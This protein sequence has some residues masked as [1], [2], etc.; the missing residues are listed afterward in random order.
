M[1]CEETFVYD[2]NLH[3]CV[4]PSNLPH[5]SN[6]QCIQCGEFQ[7]W[8]EEASACEECPEDAPY[9][10][11]GDCMACP[12]GTTFDIVTHRCLSCPSNLVYNTE[13][14]KCEC[15]ADLPHYNGV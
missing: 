13:D 2:W 14:R 1:S 9:L 3:E 7:I 15:P 8:N 5:L 6:G 4:C 12:A 11:N 10:H